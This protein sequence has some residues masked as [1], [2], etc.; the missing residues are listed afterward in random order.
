MSKSRTHSARAG[1]N[2]MQ[3]FRMIREAPHRHHRPQHPRSVRREIAFRDFLSASPDERLAYVQGDGNVVYPK[4][5]KRGSVVMVTRAGP[6]GPTV[7]ERDPAL[8]LRSGRSSVRSLSAL[9]GPMGHPAS[10]YDGYG[11]APAAPAGGYR[12]RYTGQAWDASLG[13][14]HYKAREYA[15]AMGRFLQPDPALYVDGPNVYA[16]VGNSPYNATDPTGMDA[17]IYQDGNNVRIVFN[18]EVFGDAAHRFNEVKNN[19][20]TIMSGTFGRYNVT[21]E[22]IVIGPNDIVL[23]GNDLTISSGPT[24]NGKNGH[25][26]VRDGYDIQITTQ[27]LDGI[28]IPFTAPDGRPSLSYSKKGPNTPAHE[29]GHAARLEDRP[30]KGD[31]LMEASSGTGLTEDDIRAIINHP[32]NCRVATE[33][34]ARYCQ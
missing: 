3:Q 28:A 7:T 14:Y 29:F 24:A 30:T 25:S 34:G 5:D 1:R 26:V 16:Y 21:T 13:M 12:Y 10:P 20:E 2:S 11:Q 18:V 9:D 17:E 15:P 23:R 27:D 6:S 32:Q 8:R 33:N 4:T 31:N 19:V 22:V